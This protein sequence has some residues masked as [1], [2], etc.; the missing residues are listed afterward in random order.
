MSAETVR[1]EQG[2]SSLSPEDQAAFDGIVDHYED[3]YRALT[4]EAS[5]QERYR[6]ALNPQQATPEEW[7]S[8]TQLTKPEVPSERQ[9]PEQEYIQQRL[10][11][12]TAKF[13]EVQS[14]LPPYE[15]LIR[16]EARSEKVPLWKR[17]TSFFSRR[18]GSEQ[19]W[20]PEQRSAVTTLAMGAVSLVPM[21]RFD[22]PIM[23]HPDYPST[24]TNTQER[25]V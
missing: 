21:Q 8:L 10:A 23:P 16:W 3:E 2:G 9:L 14:L 22:S 11:A 18:K 4:E 13:Y 20:P 1:R 6:E 15:D 12:M 25:R 17:V 19:S 5:E 7:E 24:L